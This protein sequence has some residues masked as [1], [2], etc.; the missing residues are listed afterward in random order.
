MAKLFVLLEFVG[1]QHQLMIKEDVLYK[2]LAA[3]TS[4]TELVKVLTNF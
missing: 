4:G 1:Y 3:K 2:R